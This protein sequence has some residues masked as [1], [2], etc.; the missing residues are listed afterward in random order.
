[1]KQL[2]KILTIHSVKELLRYKSFLFLIFFLIFADRMI[3][4][5][6]KTPEKGFDWPQGHE[7]GKHTA[8]FIFT[9][10]PEKLL[11]WVFT[12]RVL[13]VAAGLFLLKQV[14]SLWPSSDMRRMHRKERGRFGVME[15]LAVLRWTQVVWDALAVSLVCGAMA[16]WVGLAYL[17]GWAIW[18][19]SANAAGLFVAGGF[20]AVAF[21]VAMAGFSYSS[22]LA[23]IRHGTFGI[24]FRH[25]VDLFL[26]WRLLWT[27][28]LF[29]SGRIVLEVLF[30]A[31]IPAS[32]ILLIDSFWLRMAVAAISATPV[33]A[34]LKMASFK[35]FLEAYRGYPLVRKEYG[36]YYAS[37]E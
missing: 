35:F 37:V 21:P 23:V 1:M 7:F 29:F 3:H 5:F 4:R 2:L 26:N 34:Y 28:W 9:Q 11:L 16:L 32:A 24:R 20:A 12:P 25:F 13:F 8:E 27:S 22:K 19:Q 10:L 14:I 6:V 15:A 36:E 18:T 17:A 30:V 31:I 33:Y